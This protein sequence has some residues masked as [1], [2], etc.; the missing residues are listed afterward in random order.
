VHD[1]PVVVEDHP[2]ERELRLRIAVEVG[3]CWR[4][5]LHR[6]PGDVHLLVVRRPQQRPVDP[7]DRVDRRHWRNAGRTPGVKDVRHIVLAQVGEP[8]GREPL[9]P[10]LLWRLLDD[11]PQLR[12]GRSVEAHHLAGLVL[13]AVVG[14]RRVDHD[15]R[16][17]VPV[18]VGDQRDVDH[19]V[20][21]V[22]PLQLDRERVA[23]LQRARWRWRPR[24]ALLVR[25]IT[26]LLGVALEVADA[27]R[28][29]RHARPLDA[30]LPR[31][32]AHQ[33]VAAAHRARARVGARPRDALAARRTADQRLAA[34]QRAVLQ[35]PPSTTRSTAHPSCPARSR[36]AR[37][38]SS[39]P[40]ICRADPG[41]TSARCSAPACSRC[42]SCCPPAPAP[43]TEPASRPERP[44]ATFT[45]HAW[46]PDTFATARQ[47]SRII[48]INVAASLVSLVSRDGRRD[49]RQPRGRSSSSR[50]HFITIRVDSDARPTS[51]SAT[52][53]GAGPRPPC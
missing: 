32:A 7:A 36:S 6:H 30:R 23:R 44:H 43:P 49:L 39:S 35:R 12:P 19:L 1:Q 17:P 11:P 15:L 18:H 41:V 33:R 26:E 52:P 42:C 27:A 48:L 28:P 47:Q 37:P 25:R 21:R 40:S 16:Q 29:G 14:A 10:E 13:H 50:E 31:L 4:P 46:T 5:V 9:G 22:R 34:Q 53:T 24:Q 8:Q 3:H 45:W 20:R 51:P 38:P 2:A